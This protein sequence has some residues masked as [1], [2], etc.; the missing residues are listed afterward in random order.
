MGGDKLRIN[1]TLGQFRLIL[2]IFNS[3]FIF[4]IGF[5]LIQS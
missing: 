4:L 2:A 3:D 5:G 1:K